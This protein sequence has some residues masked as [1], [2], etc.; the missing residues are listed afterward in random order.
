MS[1][2]DLSKYI[3]ESKNKEI[4]LKIKRED[5][6][7]EVTLTKSTVEIPS[8]SSEVIEFNNKKIGYIAIS[9]FSSITNKQFHEKLVSLEE[10]GIDYINVFNLLR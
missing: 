4:I 10:E 3:K 1:L 2:E 9:L 7:K 5:I 6:E 8:V